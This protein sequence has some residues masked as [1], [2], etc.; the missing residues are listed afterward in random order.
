MDEM[1]FE[2]AGD[3]AEL[4]ALGC[5]SAAQRARVL[6][7]AR[8]CGPCRE[9]IA[10][11]EHTASAMI[12]S[13]EMF[14]PPA[15]LRSRIASSRRPAFAWSAWSVAAAM[16]V[17]IALIGWLYAQNRQ[18]QA[19]LAQQDAA[20]Q[21]LVHSHFLHAQFTPLTAGAPAA[22]TIVARDGTW[23]YVLI[24]APPGG[25][26]IGTAVASGVRILGRPSGTARS[27]TFYRSGER[28]EN[29]VLLR[30]GHAVARVTLPH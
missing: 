14:E 6:E 8:A 2:H 17:C 9:R 15:A 7:H 5:L 19:M 25:L 3:L 18:S 4:Y 24:A 20:I 21:A 27:C 22:K 10:E 28:V 26:E 29:L 16:A 30:E 23:F 1:N 12:E 11:A 13:G